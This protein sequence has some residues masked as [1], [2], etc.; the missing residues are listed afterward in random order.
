VRFRRPVAVW[1]LTALVLEFV[2]QRV[3]SNGSA[4]PVPAQMALAL[5]PLVPSLLFMFALVRTVQRMD[6][7]QQR[8]CLESV[9]IAFVCSLTVAFVFGGL[10]QT[11]VYRPP[12]DTVGES[13]L[14][15][16]AC[17]YVYSSWKYR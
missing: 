5:A 11:G 9:F 1:A 12:W 10:E 2:V 8:I 15:F 4:L 17:A 3:L 7:M 6:E 16:W 13:M 14:A